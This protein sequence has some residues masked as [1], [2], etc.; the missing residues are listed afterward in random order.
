MRAATNLAYIG[1]GTRNYGLRPIFGRPRGFWELQWVLR[2]AARPD[3]LEAR[4]ARAAGPR[5][6]VS[7]PDSP[8]GWTDEGARSAEV[9]VLH[10]RV[11]PEEL[12]AAV[13]PAKTLIVDL[14]ESE[15][16]QQRGRLEEIR[17]AHGGQEPRLALKLEQILVEVAL[18]VL[19]RVDPGQGAGRAA[20]RIE[21]ALHWYEENIGEHPSAAEVA[22]AVGVSPAH[23]RRLFAA[24]GKR[25][26]KTEFTR[27]R[28]AV[29]SRCLREGWKLERIAG[30]LGYSEASAF[31]RAFSAASGQSPRA[32]LKGD[33]AARGKAGLR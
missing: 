2:G 8:H 9:F 15:C 28:I 23:L 18:L 14:D 10:F 30:Y 25:P 11:V 32:W 5:L 4:E 13:N 31:S 33:R 22:R 6:Y 27:L 19:D 3:N 1:H 7:H 26:P 20:D 29:A 21:Q 12:A 16:R 17:Q 24:A